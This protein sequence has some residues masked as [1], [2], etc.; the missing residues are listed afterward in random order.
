MKKIITG[1]VVAVALFFGVNAFAQ[2][3][4]TTAVLNATVN[5][6]GAPATAWF[7]YGTDSN[8]SNYM[9]TKHESIGS[10]NSSRSFSQVIND[11]MPNTVYYFRVV[12]NN[13]Y[14][15]YRAQI[16]SFTSGT[17]TVYTNYNTVNTTSYVNTNQVSYQP[18]TTYQAVTTYQ[19]VT[20]Y[21][22][23]TT[24][25]PVTG[26]VAYQPIN[27]TVAYQPVNT[28]PVKTGI[29]T[30]TQTQKSTLA[31]ASVL[32]TGSFLPNTFFGWLL[33]LILVL[34]ILVLA[35]RLVRV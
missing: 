14:N 18:I 30:S 5:P 4:P 34:A 23:V 19:P 28:V 35:R 21:K 29:V 15:T 26:A 6:G 1:S 25:Q 31:A 20:T 24:Y 3:S 33:L 9:E 32:G 10:Y 7:E 27:N 13:G 16:L 17:D 12:T 11:V 8:L 22:P 2:T